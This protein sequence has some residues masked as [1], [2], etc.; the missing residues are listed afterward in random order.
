MAINWM[1]A[2]ADLMNRTRGGNSEIKWLKRI[3]RHFAQGRK[4]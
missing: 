2:M 1:D 3:H 4:F